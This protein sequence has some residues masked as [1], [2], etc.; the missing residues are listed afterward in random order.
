MDQTSSVQTV[1]GK[2]AKSWTGLAP[3]LRSRNFRL[4]WVGQIVSLMG[5]FLQTVAESW[6]IYQ[7]TGSTLLLGA[8]GFI[9]LLP[10][11]PISFLGGVV[12]DRVPRRKLIAV[13]QLGLMTQAAVFGLLAA[14]GLIRVWH[15]I[16]LDFVMGALYALDQPARQAFLSEIV[17]RDDLANAI[18]LNGAIFQFSRVLGQ[19]VSGVL[20]A[21]VGAG[22]AMLLN[23]ATYLA[24]VI[25]LTMIR[26]LDLR[27]DTQQAP[28]RIAVSE[29]IVTLWRRP[30]LVGAIS[31]MAAVGG[32]PMATALMMPAFAEEVLGTDARGLGVLLASGAVGSVLSTLIVA[33]LGAQRRGRTLTISSFLVPA[34]V[35]V[36]SMTRSVWASSLVLVGLGAV[37]SLLQAMAATLVQ[38]SVPDRVRGR[39]M[40]LYGM[41]IIGAP[42]ML[43]LV[44]G[45]LAEQ[46][47]L[48]ATLALCSVLTLLYVGGVYVSGPGV[49]RLD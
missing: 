25:A 32:L 45:A 31:L 37:Q 14:T 11:V 49:R 30:A 7:L 40:S 39:V 9:S 5:T 6:L 21:L 16:L 43:G 20:I 2:R 4:F 33:R 10:V 12:V 26:V 38:I 18:A 36:L 1:G 46:R 3:A 23:A 8:I 24:P 15:I 27:Q 22:G 47:G 42:K 13:T 41:L 17:E 48:P 35:F 44:I 34:F 28:L 19:A 29:G